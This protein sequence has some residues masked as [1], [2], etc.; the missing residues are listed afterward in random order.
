MNHLKKIYEI[1]IKT[2]HKGMRLDFFLANLS[3][4]QE[5]FGKKLSRSSIVR[6]IKNGGIIVEN[7]QKKPS[8]LLLGHETLQIL[9]EKFESTEEKLEP[10]HNIPIIVIAE[11]EHFI[12]IDKPAGIQ[13]HPSATEKRN[14][15]T[16]WIIAKYPKITSVGEPLRPGIVHRLDQETSGLLLIAKNKRSF[17]RLKDLFKK[18]LI[19]KRYHALVFG[20]PKESTVVIKTPL[21]RSNRGDR[22]KAIFP[23]QHGKGAIRSAETHYKILKTFKNTSLVE[24][25]P[26]TGRTHQIRVHMASIG[27]PVIGD[28]LY[29]SKNS[30]N[31]PLQT[32]RHLLHAIS[33]SFTLFRKEYTFSSPLPDDFKNILDS[34]EK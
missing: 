19:Q 22:Q 3:D 13:T 34:I 14:T 21:A 8:Y 24:L 27:H 9:P 15:V 33:L 18:H 25:E 7:E 11:N 32:K 31:L 26:R 30:R 10:K 5:I 29:G 28:T 20:I 1:S 2:E 17:T 23:G 12:V 4:F 6:N 16:N